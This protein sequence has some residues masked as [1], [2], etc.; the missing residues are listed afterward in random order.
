MPKVMYHEQKGA[1]TGPDRRRGD[2]RSERTRHHELFVRLHRTGE[3]AALDQLV[4]SFGPLAR[5]LARR[6]NNTSEPYEDL[7]QVAQLGL[8]KAIQQF[9]PERG[10]PFQAYAIP[11]ILGELR[12]YFRNS[13][14]SVHVPR[15]V[16][17]RALEVR[18]TERA[19]NEE[20]GRSPTVPE[21][22]QFMELSVEQ[23]LEAMHALRSYGSVSLDAP[24]ANDSHDEDSSYAE[25]I[26]EEDRRFD[27]VELGASV[28]PALAMLEPDQRELLRM[29]YIEEMTQSQ[30]AQRIGVSQMQVS[31]LLQRCLAELRE[32]AGVPP[33][34]D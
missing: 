27:L 28:S 17:E 5:S 11:T 29:R 19:L 34:E 3:Q 20:H 26:G 16:Q 22:A 7:C 14:W 18:D 25:T 12:R 13:S 30:I 21:L 31:R 23:V 6:Y 33:T 9:D 10:F 8:I 32:L 4:E 1:V 15:G 2:G 24:R